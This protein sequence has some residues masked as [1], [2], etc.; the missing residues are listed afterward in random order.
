M[1]ELVEVE[2]EL[3]IVEVELVTC[4]NANGI[5]AL[6]TIGMNTISVAIIPIPSNV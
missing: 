6:A 3:V 4:A 5:S 2:V 1:V